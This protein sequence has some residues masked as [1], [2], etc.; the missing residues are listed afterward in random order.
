MT[1]QSGV[2]LLG[3]QQRA[4]AWRRLATEQFDVVVIGG[5]VVGAGAALDA[6]TRGLRVA[7]V[8]ARDFAS[9]TSSRS[10]K[11]FHGGLRYLEQLE[12]GL[13]REALR[14]RELALTT[15]APHLVRPLKF[16]FPLTH[17]VWERPYVAAG[18][19]LYD[20]LG[21][22]KSVPAQKHLTRS[23]ALRMVPGLKRNS[24]VGG[25]RYYDTVVDDARHT[26][27]VART[28]AHYGAVVR[29]STQVVGFLREADRVSGVRVRDSEDGSVTEV[30]AH[31]VINATGVW[32]DEIQSL[33]RQRGRFRVRASKGVHIVVPRDRIVSD[34]AIILRTEKSVLFV[35]PWGNH[36]II[37]TTDTD[38]NLDLAH[39][40]ATKVDIDYI[41]D[42]V[43]RVLVVPLTHDDIDGVYAGLRP[44]LAG[45]SDETSKLSREHAVARVAPGLVAIAGGKYTTY[46][47]MAEDAIDLAAE[48]IPARIASS[49]TAKVPL[50]GADGYFA[51]VNQTMHLAEQYGLHPYRVKHLLDRYGS[52]VEDVLSL[53]K[54]RPE[55]LEPLTDAPQY[56]QVE[57]V[58]GAAAEG[59]LHLEDL[60]ARRTRISIEYPHRGLH[61]AEQTARLVAPVLGW[62]DAMIDREVATYR[63]RV[64][65]E[66]ESQNRP[67]DESA[68][69]LRAAAPEARP[70]ILEP[71][72]IT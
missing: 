38:W 43:N 41:L 55:L 51:L 48:D 37:G 22:A 20:R 52:L 54:G 16:L 1:N 7:L 21:G 8:E 10:S 9:G 34:S 5:G 3:P 32:T 39:P 67:D 65:A 26:M 49:I 28:A 24:L 29:T 44:L 50:V 64:E 60:L 12:F 63:A 17:R 42:H 40:A 61:C 15:L 11:M 19:F 25:I 46:R 56:L 27:T 70:E 36:W 13:V 2:Q 23:G 18:I 59:A 53:A 4:D 71:V 57:V 6:A 33:S 69:A 47:V 31:A 68:D 66:I 35:I 45:E 72:P 14:E 62:D 30:R 58:Y